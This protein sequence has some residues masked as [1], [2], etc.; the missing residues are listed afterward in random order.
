M[1]AMKLQVNG[2]EREVDADAETPLLYVLRDELGV[3]G[4]K[5]GC[6][7]GQC[8]ACAVLIDGQ[9][10]Y[11][12]RTPVSAVAASKIVTVEGLGDDRRRSA[13]QEA[14][15]A[16]Q[17]AQCGYCIPGM[18]VAAT[19]LLQRNP[20]PSDAEIRAALQRNLCRCGS[21]LRIIRAVKRA[22]GML[23]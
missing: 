14:F 1:A 5:F 18:V 4:P 22:A 17:A 6:G 19:G 2:R 12:C 23:S 13:V 3:Q 21:H 16:E 9:V 15:I 7:L 8:S 10:R 11:S 20:K